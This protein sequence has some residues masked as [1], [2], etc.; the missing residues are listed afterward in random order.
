MLPGTL[1]TL[2]LGSGLRPIRAQALMRDA[3]AQGLTFEFAE[4]DL[5]ERNRLRR[6]LLSLAAPAAANLETQETR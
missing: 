4:M 2:K 5:D 6:L 1:V 3:R